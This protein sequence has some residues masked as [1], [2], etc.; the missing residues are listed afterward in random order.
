MANETLTQARIPLLSA[1]VHLLALSLRR[2][3]LSRPT[4]ISL[5][6]TG[7]AC[8]IVW[9]WSMQREPTLRKFAEEIVVPV[10]V[11]FLVPIFAISYGTSAVGGE[12]EDRTLVYLLITPMP[13]P[14]T[15]LIKYLAALV[16]VITWTAGSLTLL[17]VLGRPWG[18]EA[19]GLFWLAILLGAAG[20][21]S[22][23]TMLGA[24]FRRGTIIS[25][26][27]AFFLEGLLGNMPG[28]VK[29]T[30]LSFYVKCMI[31][32]AGSEYE[33]GPLI[34]R[35]LFLPISGRSAAIVLSLLILGL[36]AGGLITFSS[37]EY[38]DLS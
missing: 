23:F 9:G 17:G 3:I 11:A 34:A 15:Y 21:T 18:V 29:R 37:R 36:F 6:L 14:L 24:A 10:H 4:V 12:R 25:L 13:R 8:I 28:I 32:D 33:I 2:H 35:E 22:L 30:S 27:Y 19:I 16:L 31:Y 38:R 26:A 1:S 7:F 5:A 20:Y